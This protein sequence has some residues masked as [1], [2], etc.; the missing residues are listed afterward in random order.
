MTWGGSAAALRAAAAVR[1]LL[2]AAPAVLPPGAAGARTLEVGPGKPY[3]LPSEAAA[4]ARD[5]DRVVIAGGE[6]LDCAVWRQ[7]GLVIEGTPGAVV[8]GRVCQDKAVFVIAG[9]DT[10]VRG[11]TLSGA[12]STAANGAGIRAEGPG[13][14]VEDVR[15][16]DNENGILAADQPRGALVV[17]NSEFVRNGSCEQACAH[18]IYAGRL[19]ELRV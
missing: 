11:L 10:A 7:S 17:R 9:A 18:G 3:A 2:L 16:L 19:A 14:L 6:Y 1:A 5:G 13:L 12:R 4:D 8:G 15:F